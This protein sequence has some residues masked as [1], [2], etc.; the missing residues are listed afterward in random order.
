MK[1]EY[2]KTEWSHRPEWIENAEKQ[3]RTLW[4]NEYKT[5]AKKHYREVQLRVNTYLQ[6][7][8]S[9]EEEL[10]SRTRKTEEAL[11]E[12]GDVPD[13]KRKR[14]ARWASDDEDQLDSFQQCD[15]LEELKMGPVDY[16]LGKTK[17]I[18]YKDDAKMGIELNSIPAMSA[19][20]ERLFSR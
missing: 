3:T 13:W 1:F 20:P 18:R 11:Q 17:D 9:T 7:P 10:D 8:A 15:V 5:G 6:A 19:D 12:F 16:W 14:R 2:F 4:E